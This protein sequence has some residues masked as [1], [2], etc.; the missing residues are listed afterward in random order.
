M[1]SM[2]SAPPGFGASLGMGM[3]A[4]TAAAMMSNGAAPMNA[5]LNGPSTMGDPR[6]GMSMGGGIHQPPIPSLHSGPLPPGMTQSGPPVMMPAGMV[7]P[8]SAP[9]IDPIVPPPPQPQPQ[10]QPP[11]AMMGPGAPVMVGGRPPT[12]WGAGPPGA[13][14]PGGIGSRPFGGSRFGPFGG[15]GSMPER[16]GYRRSHSVGADSMRHPGPGYGM[17]DGTQHPYDDML[18][19]PRRGG[20]YTTPEEDADETAST[21]SA[22]IFGASAAVG[23]AT[24]MADEATAAAAEAAEGGG[25]SRGRGKSSN[26]VVE[27]ETKPEEA[28]GGVDDKIAAAAALA[29]AAAVQAAAAAAA[30]PSPVPQGP[31]IQ[32][33]RPISKVRMVP[34]PRKPHPLPLVSMPVPGKVKQ[35]S[36]TSGDIPTADLEP[37]IPSFWKH[38]KR[39][40]HSQSSP[41]I[42]QPSSAPGPSRNKTKAAA[43]AAAAAVTA[44]A[45]SRRSSGAAA[46]GPP[47]SPEEKDEKKE[48]TEETKP[49]EALRDQ[50]P[51]PAPASVPSR[52]RRSQA[53]SVMETQTP[54]RTRIRSLPKAPSAWK[55]VMNFAASSSST[56]SPL[57]SSE[58]GATPV[59]SKGEK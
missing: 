10:P 26:K 1:P 23:A 6:M 39:S 41:A 49:S 53:P 19:M 20:L 12:T 46:S 13:V 37:T 22:P 28:D 42:R 40:P 47:R 38:S 43:A 48:E 5:P 15:H 44:V 8:G 35:R 30:T 27:E 56:P 36:S 58:K 2:M 45:A 18:Y 32:P 3:L 55:R 21:K 50:V 59:D 4:G 31:R 34:T 52:G 14:G 33:Q 16:R 7:P 11:H 54:G 57:Q 24:A 51:P 9:V 29:S 17:W 25:I